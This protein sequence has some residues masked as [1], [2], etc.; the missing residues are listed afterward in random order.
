MSM[1]DETR[2]DLINK[3]CAVGL[4]A[5]HCIGKIEVGDRKKASEA[6]LRIVQSA[7]EGIEILRKMEK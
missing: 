5:R 3:L 6:C 1:T 2:H 4:W 7:D